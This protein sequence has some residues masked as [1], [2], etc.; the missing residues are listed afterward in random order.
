M[1]KF[2]YVAAGAERRRGEGRAGGRHAHLCAHRAARAASST[3]GRSREKH[4]AHAAR[5]HQ[6]PHQAVRADAPVP[7]ARRVH[8][9]RRA[10]SWTRSRCSTDESDEPRCAAGHGARSATTCGP[11]RRCPTPSSGTPSDFPAFYRG[12]L[13]SA[14]LTG[15]L[16][17]VLD[18]LS[19]YIER[20]LE[21]RRKIKSAITYPAIIVVMSIVTVVVLAAFVLPKFEDFF[22]SLDAE[23]PLPTR[24]LHGHDRLHRLVRGAC[25]WRGD[26]RDS[27]SR[28][29]RRAIPSRS[30][31]VAPTLLQPAGPRRHRPL[32]DRRALLPDP[33]LDGLGRRAAAPRR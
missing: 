1:P 19:V 23:L 28:L 21:A 14:E 25:C 13:R 6:D 3:S 18:Q 20:D 33:V 29:R 2:A 10:R 26:C 27:S 15:R 22:A 16:D 24:M 9:R 31:A 11:A 32:R 30:P 5:A 12:I 8:P 17:T 4:G 7:A